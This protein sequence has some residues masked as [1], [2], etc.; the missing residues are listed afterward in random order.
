[1]TTTH[2]FDSVNED[3]DLAAD[4][5]DDNDTA[6]GDTLVQ[7]W[8]PSKIRITTKSFTLREVVEQIK[9]REIDLT[10][11]FQREYVWKQRQRTRLIESIL[12]GIPL[13]AFYF[14][15]EDD[16]TYQVVDGVQRLS[17][18]NLFMN[19]GHVLGSIDLEYLKDLDGLKY[20]ELD[21]ASMRRFRSTQ[22][23]VHIIE[24][25]TPDE[26]KYDIFGRVNTLGSPLSAQEIRHA[27]SRKRSREFLHTLSELES[28]DQATARNFFRRNPDNPSE[29]VRD[30]GRMMNRELVLRFCAFL[31]FKEDVYRQ[32]SSLDA[33]LADYT[34][35][36]DERSTNEPNLSEADLDELKAKFDQ[37]MTNAFEVL[38]KFAFRR[39]QRTA[40]KRGPINR[41]LF[42]AQATAL[43]AYT[44]EEL[45]GRESAVVSA[46][47][48][49][50]SDDEYV[51]SI[52]VGTGDPRRVAY[53]LSRTR[54]AL[55][56]VFK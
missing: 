23:V 32:Y 37:A 35:R 55:A 52:T 41:A 34:K 33:Y 10:P 36:L 20:S 30:S 49:L 39:N 46:L 25:Q 40:S 18:I 24:P 13:P 26:V 2:T 15:Q 7:P 50:F 56:E 5:V 19:D 12:L 21:Q 8:N 17:T 42:E 45:W 53:R 9:L 11:D 31:D 4:V 47:Q 54:S 1:M 3:N 51:R 6:S 22:I 43:A 28:F 16:G 14:N 48:S 44:R 29:W 27:M 38:K